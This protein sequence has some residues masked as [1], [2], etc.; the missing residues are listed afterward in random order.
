MKEEEGTTIGAALVWV[1][2]L[3]RYELG[4]I[5]AWMEYDGER[6]IFREFLWDKT[7]YMLGYVVLQSRDVSGIWCRL[8]WCEVM[9]SYH[10]R[11]GCIWVVVRE[12]GHV[13]IDKRRGRVLINLKEKRK[14]EEERNTT[15]WIMGLIRAVKLIV[16]TVNK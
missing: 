7:L 16:D 3:R 12:R 15:I 5:V 6:G 11:N 10:L 8:I 14:E 9:E 13:G 2:K 4:Q 1:K